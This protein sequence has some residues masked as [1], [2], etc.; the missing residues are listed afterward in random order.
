MPIQRIA[1]SFP[2]T[3]YLRDRYVDIKLPKP[4]IVKYVVCSNCHTLHNMPDSSQTTQV[5]LCDKCSAQ[6]P[7]FKRV[8]TGSKSVRFIP[9]LLFPVCSLISSLR[10]LLAS[11]GFTELCEEW[12]T[13]HVSNSDLLNDV[14]DGKLWNEF[15][16]ENGRPFFHNRSLLVSC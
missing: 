6:Q 11:P 16:D 13:G 5:K 9:R 2:G 12:R 14:F 8:V 1:A 15:L 7:L 4:S 10:V 3:L